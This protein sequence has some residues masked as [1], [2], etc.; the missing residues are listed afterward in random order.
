MDNTIAVAHVN[1]KGGTRFP[2]LVSLTLELW[3]WCPQ[4]TILVTAQPLPDKL[5]EVADRETKESYDSSVWQIDPQVIQ[6]FIRRCNE[7]LFASRPTA[8]L[9]TYASW[10]P[11]PGA[12]YTDAMTLDWLPLKRF[13]FPPFSLMSVV[14]KKAYQDKADLVQVAP[15]WQAQP[16]WPTIL[17]L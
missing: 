14:L 3:Q 4:R 2:Q 1:N 13:A 12:T 9:P 17:N 16:W 7:D 8:F 11:D 5:N 15:V 10:K 6:P